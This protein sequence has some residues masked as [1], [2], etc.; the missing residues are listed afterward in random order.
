MGWYQRCVLLRLINLTMQND[1]AMAER[2][3][4]VPL[5]YGKVLTVTALSR[6]LQPLGGALNAGEIKDRVGNRLQHGD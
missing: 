3:K 2:V 1:I 4:L 5:A 6:L